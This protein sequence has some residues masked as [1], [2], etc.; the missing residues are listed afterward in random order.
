MTTLHYSSYYVYVIH[1]EDI[2]ISL[3]FQT[4]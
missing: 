4:L 1:I 3:C 2:I